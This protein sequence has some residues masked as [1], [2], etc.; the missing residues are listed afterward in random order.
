MS[1][2]IVVGQVQRLVGCQAILLVIMSEYG[3]VLDL[4][5]SFVEVDGVVG[6][7]GRKLTAGKRPQVHLL[8]SY[9]FAAFGDPIYF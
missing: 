1:D 9:H 6:F 2:I 8:R 7:A 5:Y 4:V 3:A